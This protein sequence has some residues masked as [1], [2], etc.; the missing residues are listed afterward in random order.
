MVSTAWMYSLMFHISFKQLLCQGEAHL[1]LETAL[2]AA[3]ETFPS[4]GNSQLGIVSGITHAI[5]RAQSG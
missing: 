5:S 2:L 4:H 3:A 1:V